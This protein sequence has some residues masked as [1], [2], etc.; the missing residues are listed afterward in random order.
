MVL[1]VSILSS[2]NPMRKYLLLQVTQYR[3]P[4]YCEAIDVS[5]VKFKLRLI[6]KV[7]GELRPLQGGRS[8][9]R[10]SPGLVHLTTARSGIS[11]PPLQ[12]TLSWLSC[13][14]WF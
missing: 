4:I 13:T 8:N 12:G 3:T 7:R 11:G 5:Y 9:D 10:N 14:S 1:P 2:Q 6:K